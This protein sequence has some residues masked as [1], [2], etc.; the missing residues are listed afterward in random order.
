MEDDVA[1]GGTLWG[2]RLVHAMYCVGWRCLV[3]HLPNNG[4]W[5][6]FTQVTSSRCSVTCQN[7]FLLPQPTTA[8]HVGRALT[9]P[10]Y[11][12]S[13]PTPCPPPLPETAS[14]W[15][16]L[17]GDLTDKRLGAASDA[18]SKKESQPT[19]IGLAC[20]PPAYIRVQVASGLQDASGRCTGPRVPQF[21]S[22]AG[23][24]GASLVLT[25]V[26]GTQHRL[27]SRV[28]SA[29]RLAENKRTT[30][31]CFHLTEISST[32]RCPIPHFPPA[33]IQSVSNIRP[34]DGQGTMDSNVLS[35]APSITGTQTREAWV[36]KRRAARGA[37]VPGMFTR[38]GMAFCDA[39]G[40]HIDVAIC[41]RMGPMQFPRGKAE[42][43]WPL[44][45]RQDPKHHPAS[46][47]RLVGF[48]PGIPPIGCL[49]R[50]PLPPFPCR[51]QSQTPKSSPRPGIP[52]FSSC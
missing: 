48:L 31:R 33:P 5:S 22:N 15:A 44:A 4:I 19:C 50:S 16:R 43:D 38:L 30:R 7:R 40:S 6:V 18:A 45:A 25:K 51:H 46:L 52:Q 24:S 8:R 21:G 35:M 11:P 12:E 49:E 3:W 13:T 37:A 1:D 20:I 23:G 42:I 17:M 28:T 41:R 27:A 47:P 29:H 10:L 32:S 14:H 39:H 26:H 2:F 34:S 9:V 36:G